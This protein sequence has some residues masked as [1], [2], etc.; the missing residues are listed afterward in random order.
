M[1]RPK[2]LVRVGAFLDYPVSPEAA[3]WAGFL[4]ADGGVRAGSRSG[5]A[6]LA[7]SLQT[8]DR[9]HLASLRD[10]LC[11]SAQITSGHEGRAVRLQVYG[12]EIV[13]ALARFGIVPRKTYLDVMPL[14]HIAEEVP[15]IRGYFDGDGC[16][17][18]YKTQG[19]PYPHWILV[20]GQRWLTFVRDLLAEPA[21]SMGSL[22]QVGSI[23]RLS[24]VGRAVPWIIDWLAGDPS[25]ERKRL[26][27]RAILEGSYA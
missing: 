22:R 6:T 7:V 25:L 12:Q 17:G 15:F 10:F 1:P 23:W 16:V 4:L 11:P 19:R 20:G 8:R 3:Y 5:G 13:L 14:L 21:G 18:I 27:E 24:Y 9:A 2:A 26:I